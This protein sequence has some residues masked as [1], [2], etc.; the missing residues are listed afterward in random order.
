[1]AS[2]NT[3]DLDDVQPE[4]R[5]HAFLA[6]IAVGGLYFALPDNVIFI[7]PRW[8]F[9]AIV[10]ALVVPVLI[11]HAKKFHKLDRILGFVLN[12]VL[13]IG[14]IVSVARL[15]DI[16]TEQKDISPGFLLRSAGLLW[17][18]NVIVFAL[19]YWRL[20]AGGPHKREKVMGH[21]RGAFLFPQMTMDDRAKK[22]AGQTDWSP[23]FID[24]FFISFN[25]STAFSP[26]DVPV[27]TRWAKVLTM[28][29]SIIALTVVALLVARAINTLGGNN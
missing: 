16:L 24:Y 12:G 5:W 22:E 15:V 18:T 3:D 20:D 1:M 6:I 4:P 21:H 19:W 25:N 13:T 17:V 10:G 27:L 9:P 8:V 28:L 14:M 26:T 11:T 2:A 29:Q 23:N 7:E